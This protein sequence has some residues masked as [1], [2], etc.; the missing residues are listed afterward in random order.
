MSARRWIAVSVAPFFLMIGFATHAGAQFG[1]SGGGTFPGQAPNAE[2][3]KNLKEPV[4]SRVYQRD[5]NDL[6]TIPITLADNL[7]NAKIVDAQLVPL[8][9]PTS[10]T[11]F[12]DGKLSGVPV[13]GPYNV[14][15]TVQLGK[16]TKVYTIGNI[17]VGDLW[18]LAGQ[19]NMEGVGDLGDV[20][21]PSESVHVLGM[22]GQWSRAEEPL[23]WLVDSP[24]PVHSGDPATR[25]ERSEATHKSRRKGAGLGLPFGVVIAGATNVPIGLVACAHGGTSMAQWDPAKKD[26]GGKS[27]YGSMIRQ[28]NLAGGKVKGVLWYQGESD[29]NDQ[30]AAAYPKVMEDFIAAVRRDFG[31]A[32]LPF[33]L[34]QIGRVI[35][36][37]DPKAWKAVQEAERLLPGRV[38]DTAVISV[39]DLELDDGIHVGT[40]GLKRAGTRLARIALRDLYGQVGATTPALERV[41][42]GPGNTLVVKFK[43]VNRAPDTGSSRGNFGPNLGNPGFQTN[44]KLNSSGPAMRPPA[45]LGLQPSRH[46]AGFSIR[47]ADGSEIPLILEAMVG[48]S[49]DA[50]ILKLTGKIPDGASLWYGWGFDPYCNLTD[51]LDMAVPVFGPVGLD[52][53]K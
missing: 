13:G 53:I 4:Y 39:I 49:R 24:D 19:S 36:G 28:V 26:D 52:G 48:P 47:A 46:V 6:A 9:G 44:I 11:A 50:V 22:N 15:V 51:A 5:E 7:E 16:Q 23:H 33:Y 12:R 43:D 3:V 14:N 37:G 21:P 41:L 30:A 35:R 42:R 45:T 38:P 29:A 8:T 10:T 40:Q 1:G 32:D 17:Y 2:A 34:V 25:A 31:Q 20:T 18:V 27:L